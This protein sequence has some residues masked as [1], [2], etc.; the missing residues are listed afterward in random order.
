MVFEI[1]RSKESEWTNTQ[2]DHF[3]YILCLIFMQFFCW[4]SFEKLSEVFQH[5]C[6]SSYCFK[7][8]R[9]HLFEVSFDKDFS[10]DFLW[11]FL[12]DFIKQIWHCFY[13][14]WDK[15][16]KLSKGAKRD[17]HIFVLSLICMHFISVLFVK[18]IHVWNVPTYL[19]L[20]LSSRY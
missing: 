17:R 7:N 5:I 9:R 10:I 13:E 4:I 15:K 11:N 1:K 3:F 8:M 14:F 20:L 18:K 19:C 2:N 6:C 12:N 16:K